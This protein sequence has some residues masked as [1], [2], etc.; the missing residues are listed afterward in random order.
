MIIP[1]ITGHQLIFCL[2]CDANLGRSR[3]LFYALSEKVKNVSKI[4]KIGPWLLELILKKSPLK[5]Q[6]FHFLFKANKNL[7][8]MQKNSISFPK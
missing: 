8:R 3:L 7:T 6:A 1:K 2:K 5:C 4:S